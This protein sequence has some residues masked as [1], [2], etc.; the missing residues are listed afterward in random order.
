MKQKIRK[1]YMSEYPTDDLGAY[2]NSKVTF[3]DVLNGMRKKIDFYNIL[4]AGD[5]IVR[6]RVFQKMSEIL[7]CDYNYIYR[8]W[9]YGA[10]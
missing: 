5:S 9:L 1:W 10:E 2:I 4:G 3:S 7:D 6:E 8:I